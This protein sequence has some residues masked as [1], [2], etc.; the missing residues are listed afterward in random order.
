MEI[1]FS[2]AGVPCEFRRGWFLGDAQL[3][4]GGQSVKLQKLTDVT[5]YLDLKRVKVWDC[6]YGPYSIRIAKRRP[7]LFGGVRPSEYRVFVNGTMI[8]EC[9]GY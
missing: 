2:V 7:W 5:T 4:I 3:Q 9:S 1:Q 6:Q 8:L